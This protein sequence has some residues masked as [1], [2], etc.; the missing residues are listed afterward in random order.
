M[1]LCALM[2]ARA[3]NN[4]FARSHDWF[5]RNCKGTRNFP[6][7]QCSPVQR[8]ILELINTHGS[9]LQPRTAL[10]RQISTAWKQAGDTKPERASHQRFAEAVVHAR[11]SNEN[12]KTCQWHKVLNDLLE[13]DFVATTEV[14]VTNIGHI[15]EKRGAQLH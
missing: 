13:D 3:A 14:R 7:E 6:M 12:M 1:N 15:R 11:A 10:L 2:C 5:Q 8:A 9:R 4:I